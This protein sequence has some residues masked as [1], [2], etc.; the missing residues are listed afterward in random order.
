[1]ALSALS[2]APA[3][4]SV[5]QTREPP[6]A[7]DAAKNVDVD[8]RRGI[9]VRPNERTRILRSMRKYLVGLQAMNEALAKDDMKAAAEAARTMGG[10][11]LY[12]VQLMFPNRAAIEFRELAFDVH[13]DF[14][15]VAKDAEEKKDAKYTLGQV[16]AIM[17]KCAHCHDTYKLQDMA[18]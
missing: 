16:A 3:H 5:A 17:K 13:R 1:M 11:N 12:E 9:M 8:N 15:V 18:H 10:I 2:L 7:P 4:V 6:V 14:D